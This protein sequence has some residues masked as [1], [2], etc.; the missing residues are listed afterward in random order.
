MFR[1]HSEVCAPLRPAALSCAVCASVYVHVATHRPRPERLPRAMR[2]Q[3]GR[4]VLGDVT[5]SGNLTSPTRTRTRA[6]L[7]ILFSFG[8]RVPH[9]AVAVRV[10]QLGLSLGYRVPSSSLMRRVAN[11]LEQA[12]PR[13]DRLSTLF[14][15]SAISAST[16]P[17]PTPNT[18][19]QGVLLHRLRPHEGGHARRS[20][21]W[22]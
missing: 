16:A 5:G 9:V 19:S 18:P 17:S 4:A 2:S 8:H 21:V 22:S 7:L 3:F 6:Q 11:G 15:P 12:L 10:Y 13:Q 1:N 20:D 14:T